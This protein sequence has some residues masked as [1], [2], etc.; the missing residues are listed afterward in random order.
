MLDFEVT[1]V[2][3]GEAARRER[4]ISWQMDVIVVSILGRQLQW[5]ESRSSEIYSR[6]N[7]LDGD[8]GCGYQRFKFNVPSSCDVAVH[9]ITHPHIHCRWGLRTQRVRIFPS[10]MDPESLLSCLSDSA[11]LANSEQDKSV[12]H[13]QTYYF[14]INVTVTLPSIPHFPTVSSFQSFWKNFAYIFLSAAI[15]FNDQSST[16]SA[17]W[18]P[19]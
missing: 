4:M 16:S 9:N 1:R 2:G 8:G 17:I 3:K 13:S 18:S 15:G 10:F 11:N 5:Q 7:N 19:Y 14:K 12:L 6:S